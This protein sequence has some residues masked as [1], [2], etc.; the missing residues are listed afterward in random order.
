M[1][2]VLQ[3]W[4]GF[5]YNQIDLLFYCRKIMNKIKCFSDE[6]LN[7]FDITLA[8]FGILA[9]LYQRC[10]E[11]TTIK[12]VEQHFEISHVTILGITRRLER[13]E[14]IVTAVNPDDRR[15]RVIMLRK[16][17]TELC[18]TLI[19]PENFM[20]NNMVSILGKDKVTAFCEILR[21]IY[22]NFDKIFVA[23]YQ[24]SKEA[25]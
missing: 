24:N 25:N 23:D 13:K 17:G 4:S 21:E 3:K 18:K 22:D 14:F 7:K 15:S 20:F 10:N 6:Y 2:S 16:K 19:S 5:M 1:C 8:Q 9:F 12:D 11:L